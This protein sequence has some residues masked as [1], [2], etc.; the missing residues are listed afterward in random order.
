MSKLMK[1]KPSKL[2]E[3]QE[4]KLLHIEK[5]GCWLAFWMLLIAMAVQMMISGVGNFREIAGEWIV[6]MCLALYLVIDCMRNGIWDR[7]M[8]PDAKTNF[9]VS[10]RDNRN[11]I[12]NYQLHK[13]SHGCRSVGYFCYYCRIYICIG[14]CGFVD[15]RS[16][17]QE[18]F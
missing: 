11:Y 9:K 12:W 13:L 14:V 18:A 7:R 3:M 4:Q 5:N 8:E 10:F 1:R 17:L 15:F 6:F 2:D 16:N